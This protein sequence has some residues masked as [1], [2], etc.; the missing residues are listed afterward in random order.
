MRTLFDSGI[1]ARRVH[2]KCRV[3][4]PGKTFVPTGASTNGHGREDRRGLPLRTHRSLLAFSKSIP[5]LLRIVIASL[6]FLVLGNWTREKVV[7]GHLE[8]NGPRGNIWCN[9]SCPCWAPGGTAKKKQIWITGFTGIGRRFKD[10]HRP[11]AWNTR[12]PEKELPIYTKWAI[13]PP[14]SEWFAFR[15]PILLVSFCSAFPRSCSLGIV[16]YDSANRHPGD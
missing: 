1:A 7:R 16:R 14:I 4:A 15:C 6:D 12:F 3:E 10:F 8:R 13:L 5:A 2:G 11:G 9:F